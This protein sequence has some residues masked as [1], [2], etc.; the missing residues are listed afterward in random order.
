MKKSAIHFRERL[1]PFV[2]SHRSNRSI[3]PT[4]KISEGE[5][6]RFLV[7][8]RVPIIVIMSAHRVI[9]LVF[10]ILSLYKGFTF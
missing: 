1:V 5:G 10:I 7:S 2:V 3:N 6:V 4:S 8:K 9:P